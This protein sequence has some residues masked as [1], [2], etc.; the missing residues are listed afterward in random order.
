MMAVKL[1]DDLIE[2]Y[3]FKTR[4]APTD[5]KDI[6]YTESDGEPMAE[7]EIHRD[8]II[9]TLHI[10]IV[11]FENVPDVCVSGCMMMYYEEGNPKKSISPD[12]YVS[13]GV[14]KRRRRIYRF[15]DE[16]KPPDFIIEFSSQ[17]TYRHDLR[18]KVPLYAEIGIKEY[19]LC[20][21]EGL[22]LPTHLIGYRLVD[23]EYVPI[24]VDADG[25]AFSETLG[26]EIR[27]HNEDIDFYDPETDTLLLTPAETAELK[28]EEEPMARQ[29]AEEELL[30]LREE[31][32]RLK[33]LTGS[34]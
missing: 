5:R 18:K 15:W 29:R 16:G 19:F 20:N 26:L 27:L 2:E 13:F 11:H 3:A 1:A 17:G 34:T 32:E 8:A 9:K 24:P 4:Y 7:T 12:V 6:E 22:Y 33:S 30:Q 23:G 28:A 31:V 25:N 21:L 14:G 10:L